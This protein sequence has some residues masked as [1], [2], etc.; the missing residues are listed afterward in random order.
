MASSYAGKIL[1]V[2]LTSGAADVEKLDL[3]TAQRFIGGAG[4]LPLSNPM[5]PVGSG[6]D[7]DPE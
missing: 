2:N 7:H 5:C 6:Q 3:D 4:L 1:R